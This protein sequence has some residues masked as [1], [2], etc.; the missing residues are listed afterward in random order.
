LS[1]IL[2]VTGHAEYLNQ[3]DRFRQAGIDQVLMKPCS[4]DL[5]VQQL[6]RLL[7]VSTPAPVHSH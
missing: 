6:R 5:I 4:S 2:A 7:S 1:R 3:P